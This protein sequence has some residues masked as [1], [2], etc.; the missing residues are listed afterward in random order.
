[1]AF[2]GE[3]RV[4]QFTA[5][6]FAH[7]AAIVGNLDTHRL[8]FKTGT[9]RYLFF[10]IPAS[11]LQQ[12]SL[13][14]FNRITGVVALVTVLVMAVLGQFVLDYVFRISFE[15]FMVGGGLL[16]VVVGVKN[17]IFGEN[18]NPAADCGING[19]KERREQLVLRAVCPLACPLLVG[20]G[21]IVTS[22]LIVQDPTLGIGWGLIAIALAFSVVLIVLNWGHL[23]MKIFG[24]FGPLIVARITM[25]FVTAIGVEFMVR[26]LKS[27]FFDCN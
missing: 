10:I 4:K 22:M 20:P 9:H 24:R 7:P 25:I 13:F 21:S 17:I 19:P 16:L 23:I 26:G 14:D 3:K 12:G 1:M 27:L 8:F 6:F 15:S 18:P 11:F 5:G 2:C